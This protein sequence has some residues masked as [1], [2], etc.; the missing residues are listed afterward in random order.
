MEM[1][2]NF[3]PAA[4]VTEQA[5]YTC[6]IRSDVNPELSAAFGPL[7]LDEQTHHFSFN[8]CISLNN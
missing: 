1:W 2:I 7:P 4:D 8:V 6:R 5:A 3:K